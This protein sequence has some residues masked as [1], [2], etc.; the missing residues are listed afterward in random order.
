MNNN[1]TVKQCVGVLTNKYMQ[2][3]KKTK[4]QD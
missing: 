2:M 3:R 4:Q 1:D